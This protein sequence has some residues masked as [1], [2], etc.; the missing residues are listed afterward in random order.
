MKKNLHYYVAAWAL[1]LAMFA[2]CS[3]EET[4][5]PID[6]NQVD[7]SE[8][9]Q[10]PDD[11]L[12]SNQ[13]DR[14]ALSGYL[15]TQT[16]ATGNNQI[17]IYRHNWAGA[18]TYVGAVSTGGSGNGKSLS[19]QG[20]L[21]IDRQQNRLFAVNA[22]SN[23][24]SMFS[25][26]PANGNL[27]LLDNEPLQS[28]TPVSVTV[29]GSFVYVVND[30]SNNIRGLQVIGGNSMVLLSNSSKVLSSS[31]AGPAQISFSPN[32]NWLH[33]TEKNKNFIRTFQVNAGGYAQPGT[34]TAAIGKTPVGFCYGRSNTL[35]VTH[36]E[37]N[38]VG[39]S[40][41]ASYSGNNSN[42]LATVNGS[43]STAQS[44]S[45]CVAGTIFGRYAFVTNNI[46]NNISSYYIASSGNLVLVNGSAAATGNAP[47]DIC[48]SNSNLFV[49][50]INSGDGTISAYL[51]GVLGTMIPIGTTSGV[52]TFGAGLVSY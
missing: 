43:I 15:Y 48:L 49:Y 31:G 6:V 9:G 51:R 30:G 13:N 50:A 21:A 47:T 3:K 40:V 10:N 8:A 41:G 34:N 23:S 45:G 20:A 2:S 19:S 11:L 1:V 16:N 17:M 4:N 39:Q 25:I 32:G 28:V 26:D 42:T 35:V 37:S 24:L 27:T 46:S 29:K 38:A 5:Q 22:G 12:L 14:I 7:I 52:T 44:G 36:A 18:L 33:V